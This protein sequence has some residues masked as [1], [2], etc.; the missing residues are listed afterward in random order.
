MDRRKFLKNSTLGM[1][2]AGVLGG[3][4]LL[5][6]GEAKKDDAP[7]IMEYRTLGRTD[8]KVSDIST[9]GPGDESLLA[10]LLDAGVNYIDTAESY[11]N[12]QSETVVGKVMKNR[13]RKKVF[14]STK[15]LVTSFPGMPVK[16]EEVSK[17]GII[18]RYHKS[19]ERLQMDYADCLM[20]HAC[21]KVA[22]LNHEG[23]HAA[24]KQLKAD[25]RVK[26]AG[27]S[28]HGSFH[29]MDV[30]EPMEKV[31]L[32][33][34]E[35]GR[36]DVY[37][38]AYNFLNQEKSEEVLRACREKGIGTTL[39]KTNPVGGY[40]SV[41]EGIAKLEKEG[42][43]IPDYY[44]KALVKFKTKFEQAEGFLKKHN[45]EDPGEIKEAAIKFCLNNSDVNTVCVSFRN[46]DDLT[47]Y[48]KLSGKRLTPADQAALTTYSKSM[49]Q[50][51]CRHA[52]GV[53]ESSCPQD[54]AV[55]TI[56]RY[57]HYFVAQ[58]REKYAMER[59]AKLASRV[60][61]QCQNCAG[62]CESACPYKVPVQTLLVLAH[63]NLTLA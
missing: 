40:F 57:N 18:K 19:L 24:V 15:Q 4:S 46:F 53:C 48:V 33:A 3:E 14:I 49:G 35:D 30:R 25:G 13:D 43:D 5:K 44:R 8:F 17:E 21:D 7:K 10:A 50:F 51:Y 41:K 6:A 32:A 16:D 55:N 58:G 37:L 2:G 39:M 42:K 62:H 61:N 52:C 1:V 28:N 47:K 36:F 29:P 27:I 63:Q 20:M 31:L 60:A 56:M 26:Y 34:A 22:D 59:Y 9:G 12:G 45:L 11:G 54:V 38:M 23:Y